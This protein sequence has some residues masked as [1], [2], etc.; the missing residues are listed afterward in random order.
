MSRASPSMPEALQPDGPAPATAPDETPDAAPNMT[1]RIVDAITTAIVERRLMPGTKLA[2]QPI[3]DIFKVSRTLVSARSTNSRFRDS[4]LPRGS[5]TPASPFYF[6]ETESLV[7]LR[8]GFAVSVVR[9]N[10]QGL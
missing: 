5:R 6:L 9:R 7:A 4:V 1:Q 3:A 10:R 8:R 2:E